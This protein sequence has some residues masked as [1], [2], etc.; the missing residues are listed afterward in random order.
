MCAV[1]VRGKIRLTVK[2]IEHRLELI[3]HHSGLEI[4]YVQLPDARLALVL[5]LCK[6]GQT[7]AVYSI[8]HREAITKP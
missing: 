4:Q 1:P 5:G 8:I 6:G 7:G 3:E 2:V